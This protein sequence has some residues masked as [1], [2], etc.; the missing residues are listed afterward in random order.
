MS[1]K[2][3]VVKFNKRFDIYTTGETA[4]FPPDKAK[5]MVDRGIASYVDRQMRP[6]AEK[7]A[8]DEDQVEKATRRRE[9]I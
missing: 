8:K 5:R 4:G 7:A 6:G 3:D 1:V 2:L 9:R